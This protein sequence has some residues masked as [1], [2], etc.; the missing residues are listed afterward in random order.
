MRRRAARCELLTIPLARAQHVIARRGA[1]QG[2]R[3]PAGRRGV[4]HQHGDVCAGRLVQRR[5]RREAARGRKGRS[6]R[7]ARG[8]DAAAR[9][10]LSASPGCIWRRQCCCCCAAAA[11]TH[12]ATLAVTPATREACTIAVAAATSRSRRRRQRRRRRRQ[13]SQSVARAPSL[14]LASSQVARVA[15]A[16]T[17]ATQTV[18]VAGTQEFT[19]AGTQAFTVTCTQA[20][21]VACTQAFAVAST[22]AFAF[23]AS[24]VASAQTLTIA[25]SKAIAVSSSQTLAVASQ[26]FAVSSSQTL[27]VASQAFTVAGPQTLTITSQ[28]L[29]IA[30]ARQVSTS[31]AF[32]NPSP[33]HAK[34]MSLTS[35][36][37]EVPARAYTWA[38]V[39]AMVGV[40]RPIL[41]RRE[42]VQSAY[43][44]FAA[45][46]AK[47]YAS[48]GS[49]L[50]I[51][52]FAFD[53]VLDDDGRRRATVPTTR[54]L[55]YRFDPDSR[56]LVRLVPNDFPYWV[57]DDVEHMVLWVAYIDAGAASND[58]MTLADGVELLKIMYQRVRGRLLTDDCIALFRN[59]PSNSS[60]PD[61]FHFQVFVRT[62]K[63]NGVAS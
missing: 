38:E 34:T 44:T 52:L 32:I 33:P 36:P 60:V 48:I 56:M 25:A 43:V 49:Y 27:A 31:F 50:K 17:V 39:V 40:P 22:Q 46:N 5:A 61:I 10:R 8:D 47:A 26:A 53:D 59:Q 55:E 30:V 37:Y 6:R 51:Q 15:Q 42:E 63:I 23:A 7:A 19:V 11:N 3:E 4:W 29:T 16:F 24:Q 1:R 62:P 45:D 13:A 57:E 35:L 58:D 9:G 20:F 18:A 14:A 54:S 12:C 21:T 41:Y 2:A 28:T